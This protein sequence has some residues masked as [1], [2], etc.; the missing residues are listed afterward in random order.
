[1]LKTDTL[2]LAGMRALGTR[3]LVG[4]I[5]LG[6]VS[7]LLTG[8][9]I[10]SPYLWV[11][12]AIALGAFALPAWNL[13]TGRND[14]TARLTLGLAAPLAPA[15]LLCVTA[16]Q[17]WQ[18]DM[19][20]VF[21]VILATLVI[22]CDWRA[23]LAGTVVTALHHLLVTLVAPHLVFG[24][25]VSIFRVLLHAVLVLIEAG[26]LMW[27][28]NALV[29]LLDHSEKALHQSEAAANHIRTQQAV[30]ARIITAVQEGLNRLATG[31]LRVRL[32]EDFPQEYEPLRVDFNQSA[33]SIESAI[34]SLVQ[35]INTINASIREINVGTHDLAQRTEQQATTIG[36]ASEAASVT[37]QAALSVASRAGQSGDLFSVAFA[38]AEQ[39]QEVVTQA[40][41]AMT[42]ISRSSGEINAIIGM[43]EGIAFQTTLLA[44][45]A[46]VEAARS[47]EAGRGFAVVATEVRALAEKC[48]EAAASIR[49]IIA[50]NTSQIGEGVELV[51][52]TGSTLNALVDRFAD[53]RALIDEIADSTRRQSSSITQVSTGISDIERA[54]QSNAAMV[55]ESN[56]ATH[57]LAQEMQRISD[58]AARFR[59]AA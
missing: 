36:G 39:S 15:A 26:I 32:T 3:L 22:L 13:H 27:T 50:R 47:G 42:A 29:A 52:K 20:M 25:D 7:T 59:C 55:E 58:L 24:T 16:G 38:D 35:S 53:L 45:N 41:N 43:I 56:A 6:L 31:D 49:E 23:I 5:A 19:H 18:V 4:L 9:V 2:T 33:A 46:G 51:E 28:A 17:D 12:M 57:A 14:A 21:F 37:S 34:S 10:S 44:L 11:A 48:A 30:R 8:L 54:T 40:R 1:M